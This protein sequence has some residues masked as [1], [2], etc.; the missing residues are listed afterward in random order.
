MH[1]FQRA[2]Q[3][4]SPPGIPSDSKP[5]ETKPG[6]STLAFDASSALLATKLDDAPCT[7]WIWDIAAAE[8]RAVL[9]FHSV[10][11]FAW[12]N[13]TREL[14]LITSHDESRPGLSYLWDPLLQG[15][16]PVV[17]EEFLSVK[18]SLSAPAK[19][20]ISWINID[21]EYPLALLS[22]AQQYRILSLGEGD[23]VP[24]TWHGA[25][26]WDDEPPRRRAVDPDV[27]DMSMDDGTAVED[28]FSFRNR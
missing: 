6:C 19:A 24:E 12:H 20:Q 11:T 2:T 15:P 28:T 16:T 22:T 5:I 23:E 7:I 17:P 18:T 3:M 14:L 8:L 25:S 27:S 26:K 9:V 10:V 13:R 4:L 1:T 21:M